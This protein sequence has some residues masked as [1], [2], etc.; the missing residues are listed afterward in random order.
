M[1]EI[2]WVKNMKKGFIFCSKIVLFM[3]T[4]SIVML[5][6]GGLRNGWESVKEALLFVAAVTIGFPLVIGIGYI[7]LI[8][9]LKILYSGK[10]VVN[11]DKM[12][13]RDLPKHCSPAICSLI[14][15]LKI[16]VY[17]DYTATILYL[18]MK[19]YINLIKDGDTYKLELAKDQD[20]SNLG[21]CE[22]YVLNVL[23]SKTKFDENQFK[24]EIIKEAQGK[25]LITDKRHSK[26]PKILLM[27][28]VII[29]A[30]IITYNINII[31]FYIIAGLTG[32]MAI[33][34]WFAITLKI[35]NETL[36]DVN[37]THYIR[38]KDGKEIALLLDGLKRYIKEYTL[39]KEKEIDYMQILEEYIPYALALEEADAV[40][41]FIKNNDKYRDLIYNKKV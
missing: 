17:K 32:M 19:K 24:N 41:E 26:T 34:G 11:F 37:D 16:D 36:F 12:Y 2:D 1:D 22:K 20:Y 21:Q 25:E 5:L 9:I 23:D 30:L 10:R 29:A 3:G 39:I 13:I 31:V 14:H 8:M 40:E 28:I 35:Q 18:C 6:I 4:L 27:L 38:T 15:D 7:I 33:V